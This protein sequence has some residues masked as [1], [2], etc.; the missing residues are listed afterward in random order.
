MRGKLEGSYF[1]MCELVT[2]R[3]RQVFKW[4]PTVQGLKRKR[5][6]GLCREKNKKTNQWVFVSCVHKRFLC[7]STDPNHA[8]E[9]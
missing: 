3:V 1:F 2:E 8:G 5:G 9:I 4:I 6:G 7:A